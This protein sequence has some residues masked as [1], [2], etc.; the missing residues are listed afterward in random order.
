MLDEAPRESSKT[1]IDEL[2]SIM[3][4]SQVASMNA[5]TRSKPGSTESRA[6]LMVSKQALPAPDS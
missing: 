3:P 5:S 6:V 1:T 2:A 4:I